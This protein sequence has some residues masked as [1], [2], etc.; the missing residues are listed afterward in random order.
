[1][2]QK[3]E[4]QFGIPKELFARESKLV[5]E[6]SINDE[7][8]PI[9]Q[10]SGTDEVIQLLN[11]FCQESY[12]NSNQSVHLSLSIKT[13]GGTKRVYDTIPHNF[14]KNSMSFKD[15]NTLMNKEQNTKNVTYISDFDINFCSKVSTNMEIYQHLIIV[16]KYLE[17]TYLFSLLA[18]YIALQIKQNPK[19]N[20]EFVLNSSRMN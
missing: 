6:M 20:N 16:S 15:I 7:Q 13:D 1:M 9:P 19:T 10:E 8:V 11:T 12:K 17:M 2:D 4:T 5:R 14:V 3:T 18:T